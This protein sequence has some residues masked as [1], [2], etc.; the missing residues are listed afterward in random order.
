MYLV[1]T[2]VIKPLV[3]IQSP[4]TNTHADQVTLYKTDFLRL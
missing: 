4:L 2:S 3:V 1:I